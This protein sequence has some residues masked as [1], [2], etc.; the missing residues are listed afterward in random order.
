[1]RQEDLQRAAQLWGDDVRSAYYDAGGV[2]W[3]QLA[4]VQ[5]RINEKIS[6]DPDVD[7]VDHLKAAHL[8]DRAPVE[9]C[10]SLCCWQGEVER[11]LGRRGVFRHCLAYDISQAALARAREKAAEE[12]L[13]GIEYVVQDV[14]TMVLPECH[15]DLIVARGALHHIAALEHVL[16]QINRGLKDDGLLVVMEYVGPSR[17]AYSRR[18]LELAT[19]ALRLLPER[20]RRNVSWSRLGRL[21]PGGKRP[22]SAWA[23]LLWLKLRN[24]TLLQALGRRIY[25]RWLRARGLPHVKQRVPRIVGSEMAVDD[26]TEAVRSA[27]IR[28]LLHEYLDIVE[29]R[30]YGGTLLMPLLDDIAGNFGPGPATD[31]SQAAAEDPSAQALLE[32]LFTIEDALM[33]AGEIDSDF[34]FIVAGKRAARTV[35]GR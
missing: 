14:N 1:M 9:H 13:E 27:E 2:M 6:G 24:G 18:Q 15:F 22:A 3:G 5:R 23:K 17:F 35:D 19:C 31:P 7:W 10:L 4:A 21:G 33:A 11:D 29:Y 12:G 16:E 8:G 20:F 34:A 30:P 26:P 28:P 32:M 25:H